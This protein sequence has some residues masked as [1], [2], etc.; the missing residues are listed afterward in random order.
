MFLFTA[1]CAECDVVLDWDVISGTARIHGTAQGGHKAG[2][3]LDE[4]DG[5]FGLYE[6]DYTYSNV[7]PVPGDAGGFQDI[8]QVAAS[9]DP[10]GTLSFSALELEWELRAKSNGTFAFRF[11]DE[12]DGNGHRGFDGLSGWGWLQFRL[13]GPSIATTQ[14]QPRTGAQDGLFTGHRRDVPVPSTTFLFALG[15]AALGIR[16]RRR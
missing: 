15:L 16:R 10:I 9:G 8:W 12:N 4:L 13:T 5:F 7:V 1:E 6:F 2:N 3:A 11:G 14:F